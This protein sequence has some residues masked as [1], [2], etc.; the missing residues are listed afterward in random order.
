MKN[1]EILGGSETLS[2]LK[3]INRKEKLTSGTTSVSSSDTAKSYIRVDDKLLS[4]YPSNEISIKSGISISNINGDF[5]GQVKYPEDA[6]R[7]D[8]E[9]FNLRAVHISGN[10]YA[11]AYT[12]LQ[13][14]FVSTVTIDSTAKTV[15]NSQIHEYAISENF[16]KFELGVHG[17]YSV[18]YII[19]NIVGSRF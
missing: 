8:N 7:V 5:D 2:K 9:L 12:D 4:I 3:I 1:I 6:A 13:T 10:D 11:V 19:S 16:L 17:D 18:L 14:I 15:T